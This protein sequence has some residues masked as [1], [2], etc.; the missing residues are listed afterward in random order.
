M[1]K[2]MQRRTDSFLQYMNDMDGFVPSIPDSV[3]SFGT[4]VFVG[5]DNVVIV[6]NLG[7]AAEAYATANGI[8]TE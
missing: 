4:D 1:Q 2:H 3:E 8:K 6:C 5:C 7:S